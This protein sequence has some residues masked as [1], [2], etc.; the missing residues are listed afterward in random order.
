MIYQHST[1]QQIL[2]RMRTIVEAAYL[3]PAAAID[4][5]DGN[6][7][8][9]MFEFIRRFRDTTD[10][11]SPCAAEPPLAASQPKKK[12]SPKPRR[13]ATSLDLDGVL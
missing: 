11:F 1:D 2:E 10:L 7:R 6:T 5:Q 8:E 12:E 9:L 3:H 4:A 13:Q